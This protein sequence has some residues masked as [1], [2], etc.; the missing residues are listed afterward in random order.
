MIKITQSNAGYHCASCKRVSY[1]AIPVKIERERVA[2]I[3]RS[4][5]WVCS[6]SCLTSLLEK[7]KWL[8]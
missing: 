7:L 5:K 4:E 6:L 1:A 8:D 3:I 2:G